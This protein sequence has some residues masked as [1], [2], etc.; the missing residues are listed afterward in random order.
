MKAQS[1]DY[2]KLHPLMGQI[3]IRHVSQFPQI[4]EVTCQVK[5]GSGFFALV[6]LPLINLSI[7]LP[8]A[9]SEVFFIDLF[10]NF[11]LLLF[12]VKARLI[13]QRFFDS[14]LTIVDLK[15]N[16]LQNPDQVIISLIGG[17]TPNVFFDFFDLCHIVRLEFLKNLLFDLCGNVPMQVLLG[18]EKFVPFAR[19][20]RV[21][22]NLAYVLVDPPHLVVP[23]DLQVSFYLVHGF[24]NIIKFYWGK[25]IFNQL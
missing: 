18:K 12:Q 17:D 15:V 13:L 20:F 23:D 14:F 21:A 8:A 22:Q 2:P 11:D 10:K 7:K 16:L 3:F 4:F 9:I 6:K 1:L 19:Q 24:L 25:N 5:F